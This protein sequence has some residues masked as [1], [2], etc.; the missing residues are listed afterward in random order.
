MSDLDELER[1]ARAATP[2]PWKNYSIN[3]KVTPEHAIYS[4][5][6]EGIPEA[7]SSEIATLLTPK[8]AEF[9]AAANPEAVLALVARVREAEAVIAE[10]RRAVQPHEHTPASL[11]MA[12]IL[13]TYEKGATQ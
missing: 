10:A 4:E 1:L 12:E 3:P 5:W 7:Q 8:N 2:G 11:H 13:S 9:I 6:L